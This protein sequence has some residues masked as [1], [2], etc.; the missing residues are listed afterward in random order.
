MITNIIKNRKFKVCS[1]IISLVLLFTAI[2]SYPTAT[3]VELTEGVPTISDNYLRGVSEGLRCSDLRNIYTEKIHGTSYKLYSST[4]KYI[5]VSTI[6]HKI[7]TGDYI[8]DG[9]GKTYTIVVTGDIYADG[10][11]D[12]NDTAA[13]KLH[14]S[15]EITLT[16]AL[17]EAADT[18]NDGRVTA[19]DYLRI[20]YHIQTKFDIHE[21]ESF[22]PDDNSVDSNISSEYDESGW[23]PGWM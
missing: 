12:I 15:K 8:K 20:K 16:D 19:T 23:T 10:V 5:S 18:N 17:Y 1:L 6:G 13:I 3:A 9:Y 21:N 7:S 14:F 11:V 4:G 22:T 2:S